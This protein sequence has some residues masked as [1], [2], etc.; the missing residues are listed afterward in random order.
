[1]KIRE[2]LNL[3]KSGARTNKYR[4]IHPDIGNE[5]DIL[6]NA[7]TMP[8]TEIGV[9]EIMLR[10]RK[11]SLAGD[12]IDDNKWS[13]TL[14]NTKDLKIRNFFLNEIAKIQEMNVPGGSY[15]SRDYFK[16]ITIQQLDHNG[17]VSSEVTL[18][19]AFINSVSPIEYTDEGGSVSTTNLSFTYSGIR[20]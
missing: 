7:S 10:G 19:N 13:C 8:G 15:T 5:F 20:H 17:D 16:E 2:T 18:E 9:V 11:F 6:V 3:I 14:Y 1:M 4:I 12:R